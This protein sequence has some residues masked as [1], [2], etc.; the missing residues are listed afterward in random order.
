MVRM[1][2]AVGVTPLGGWA[3][4]GW[5]DG[6]PMELQQMVKLLADDPVGAIRFI[7]LDVPVLADA[8]LTQLLGDADPK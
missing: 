2:V 1:R 8:A 5:R 7:T 4:V 6:A 3:I